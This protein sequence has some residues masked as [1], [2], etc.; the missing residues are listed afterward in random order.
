MR[1]WWVIS[2][3][4][5][6]IGGDPWCFCTLSMFFFFFLHIYFSL[7][8]PPNSFKQHLVDIILHNILQLDHQTHSTSNSPKYNTSQHL[9]VGS[10]SLK[11]CH[12][13]VCCL[14]LLQP[15]LEVVFLLICWVIQLLT[16]LMKGLTITS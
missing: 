4:F 7:V 16:R 3:A 10:A 12:S 15:L 1:Y 9:A 6:D 5:R 14:L 11:S 13:V 2:D 8:K